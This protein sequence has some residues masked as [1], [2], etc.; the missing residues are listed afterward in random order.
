MSLRNIKN[1][2]EIYEFLKNEL[3]LPFLLKEKY[4]GF[5]EKLFS[6]LFFID[7]KKIQNGIKQIPKFGLFQKLGIIDLYF[8]FYPILG[9][10][11]IVFSHHLF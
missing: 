1:I 10:L 8:I 11:F 5:F 6:I 3:Y 7:V 4:D 9:I 2:D